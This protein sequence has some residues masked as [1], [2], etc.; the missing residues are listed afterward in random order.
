MKH[1]KGVSMKKYKAKV[2]CEFEIETTEEDIE[3]IE[4]I[5]ETIQT[6]KIQELIEFK[7]EDSLQYVTIKSFK[8]V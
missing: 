4:T 8:E 5:K 3:S 1:Q 7:S 6:S 2:I